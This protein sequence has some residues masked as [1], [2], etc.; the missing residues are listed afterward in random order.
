MRMTDVSIRKL[1]PK[2]QRYEVWE[3]GRTGLGVRVSPRNRKTFVF[4]YWL[5][6]KARR[7]TLGVYGEGHGQLSLADANVKH[8]EARKAVGEGRDPA[9]ETVE[10]RQA[11]REAETVADLVEAYLEKWARPRKRSAG[12]D[13]RILNKEI[14]PRWG[15]RK[16]KD[17]KRREIIALL[18]TVVERGA[19][20]QANRT[21]ACVRRMFNWAI[22]RDMIDASPCLRVKAP[23][24]ENRRDRTLS[25]DEIST[26]WHGLEK[27]KMTETVRLALKF[28]LVTAQ[29]KGEVIAAEWSELDRDRDNGLWTIPAEKAK[30]G[31]Q[32]VVP[33]SPLALDVLDAI[34]VNVTPTDEKGKALERTT[35]YLFPSPRGARST[36]GPAVDH[37]LRNNRALIGVS[38]VV[39]HDLRRTAATRMASLGVDRTVL[40]KI[41]NHVDRSVTGRY[42]THTYV[43]EKRAALERW[44]RKLEAII[45]GKD[46]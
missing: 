32:H 2:A 1:K 9:S 21:L 31:V 19:P 29:R 13:E 10:A 11:E 6:G 35:P 7:M 5:N 28:Q 45:S 26:F 41:L 30:N 44:A 43:P 33:L 20:I 37:A 38:D 40:A 14:V 16:A 4:M 23:S 12:E 39:P 24:P 22:E 15:T 8:A 17:I 18:D 3:D 25:D 27:A 36:T 46:A 42:D 34:E